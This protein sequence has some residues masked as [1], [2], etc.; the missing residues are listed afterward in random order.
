M[1]KIMVDKNAQ[2]GLF[3]EGPGKDL[4]YCILQG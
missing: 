2:E 1:K 3:F 4:D